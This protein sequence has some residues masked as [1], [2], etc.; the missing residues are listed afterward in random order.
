[1]FNSDVGL[2]VLGCL[3][4]FQLQLKCQI[5]HEL[6]VERNARVAHGYVDQWAGFLQYFAD[7]D[8][9]DFA[10]L[11]IVHE[12]GEVGHMVDIGRALSR[13]DIQGLLD[14]PFGFFI[15]AHFWQ[16]FFGFIFVADLR[17][18]NSCN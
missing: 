17:G 1:M 4:D 10:F 11:A 3:E 13:L 9:F 2:E 12:A 16:P 7:I 15:H 5:G 14:N 8:L 6:D 18:W